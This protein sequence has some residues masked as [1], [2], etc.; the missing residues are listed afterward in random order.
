MK[1]AALMVSFSMSINVGSASS[2]SQAESNEIY[3]NLDNSDVLASE[4]STMSR[5]GPL[6]IVGGVVIGMLVGGA[7]VF[8]AGNTA[9]QMIAEFGWSVLDKITSFNH[10]T[11]DYNIVVHSNGVVTSVC[12]IPPCRGYDSVEPTE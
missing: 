12:A 8:V 3:Y 4:Y 6:L 1:L 10:L 11:P 2:L 7:I 9:E 5:Q